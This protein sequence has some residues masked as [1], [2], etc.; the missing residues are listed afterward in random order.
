M[1][2]PSRHAVHNAVHN[3]VHNAVHNFAH[4]G[5]S[6]ITYLRYNKVRLQH[7]PTQKDGYESETSYGLQ[8]P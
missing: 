8:A 1:D 6:D 3:V 2:G 4:N 5:L 7:W